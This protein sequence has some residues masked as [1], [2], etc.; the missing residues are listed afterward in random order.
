MNATSPRVTFSP[1]IEERYSEI[2]EMLDTIL[3]L[4]LYLF[5]TTTKC[6]GKGEYF[7]VE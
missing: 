7:V 2:I 1:R 3:S 6:S 4:P 5:E